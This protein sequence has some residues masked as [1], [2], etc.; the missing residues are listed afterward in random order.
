MKVVLSLFI[1]LALPFQELFAQS[2]KGKIIDATTKE[3]LSFANVV[4]L[5]AVD[6]AFVTGT[7]S[8]D[9]GT[10]SLVPPAGKS[11]L[12][13]SLIG[14]ETYT[15]P[16]HS[17]N[18]SIIALTPKQE[19]LSEVVVT[20]HARLFKMENGGISAD[21]Q[22]TPLKS[23]GN[24]SEVLG[25][26]PFVTKTDNALT[27]LG[28]GTPVV[29]I[30]NR[31]VR[32]NNDLLRIN[33]KDIKKVTVITNPGAEY[34][35]SVNA[36]IKVE[37]A[38][39]VGDGLSIDL[40]TYNRYN[41]EWY[42]MN[43]ASFNYRND[44]LDIFTSIEYANL[45]FPKDRIKNLDIQT[46]EGHRTITAK[47]EDSDMLKF[48]TPKAGFNYMINEKHSFGAQYEYS[49]TY[50]QN[51]NYQIDTESSLEGAAED[52]IHTHSFS[53][54]RKHSHYVNA[55]YNGQIT[56]WL[57]AKLDIDYKRSEN[58]GYNGAI[59]TLEN[60]NNENLQTLNDGNYDLYAAKL[61][62]Q[63]RLW[64]GDLAYGGEGSYTQNKQAIN[65]TENDGIPGINSNTNDMR[66]N[67]YAAFISYNH[68]FGSFSG[69]IGLRYE[70][71]NSQYYENER[72]LKEQS[73]RHQRLF[74]TFRINYNVNEDLQMELA[75]RNTVSRP[76]YSSL[77]GFVVYM[78]PY[79]YAMGNPLLRPTYTN[80]LTYMLRWKQFSLMGTYRKCNDYTAEI[81]ELYMGN[82]I[83]SRMVNI[84]NAQFLTV[85]FNY[86][87]SFGIWR[88]NYDISLDKN[89]VT[90]GNPEIAYNTPVFNFNLRNGF[91]VK[92]WNFGVDING[93]SKGDD[94]YL[95]H[96]TQFSWQ[97]NIYVNT[98]FC[99]D[100][101]LIG[102]QG[103]DIFNT[104]NDYF[105]HKYNGIYIYEEDN[106]YR[107]TLMFSMT[108]RFNTS[109]KRYKGSNATNE[110]WRL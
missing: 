40:W 105:S 75:Y 39:P 97:T 10:F 41:S 44:K 49:N 18:Q 81:K 36:V 48:Y 94:S 55:Y 54:N 20:G 9:D 28:K 93:R 13:I 52:P 76:S 46:E 24:L 31:L 53:K 57:N 34:D 22:N 1:L 89:Y 98:A 27:V 50:D 12:R 38:R 100:K 60:F 91:S 43:R 82:S 16:F 87:S 61:T 59:N 95:Y 33:S 5:Q 37:T 62:L 42:T 47:R 108:Y 71:V 51:H 99:K 15:E 7:V 63:T 30:N 72:L 58:S 26:M 29:Y 86:N 101:L 73:R 2:F 19:M 23:I 17:Q 45:A 109:P 6:S 79:Q 96:N 56:D 74:P 32:D 67:L 85:V 78:G 21:I 90:Y 110:I 107:R 83:L 69:E 35:A 66:Q 68:T 70:N 104:K 88:P 11:I 103:I 4:L 77:Q 3:T 106:M 92:G 102:L 84:K 64:E 8:G 65:V 14:Y 80:S 25:Q